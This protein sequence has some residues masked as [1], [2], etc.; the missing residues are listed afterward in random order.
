MDARQR[1]SRS[2]LT[3]LHEGTGFLPPSV[4]PEAFDQSY[5]PP[6]T[7]SSKMFE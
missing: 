3:K 5:A 7:M 2:T 4:H 1:R 6:T